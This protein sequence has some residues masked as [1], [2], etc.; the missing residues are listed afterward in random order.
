MSNKC[1]KCNTE[2]KV[3]PTKQLMSY[4]P[5]PCYY[6]PKCEPKSAWETYAN[7]CETLISE[8]YTTYY[9]IYLDDTKEGW[10]FKVSKHNGIE[11]EGKPAL[12]RFV[13]VACVTM[14][15]H[16]AEALYYA[17]WPTGE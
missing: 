10:S 9:P 11:T 17:A 3:D 12:E 14:T 5:Q 13:C 2:L 7:Q 1:E 4:P 8:T 15:R 6:C 16:V